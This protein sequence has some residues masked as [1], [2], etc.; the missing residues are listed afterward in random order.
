MKVEKVL[1]LGN[2]YVAN[3]LLNSIDKAIVSTDK[4]SKFSDVNKIKQK[5]SFI[6]ETPIIKITALGTDFIVEVYDDGSIFTAVD[7]GKVKVSIKLKNKNINLIKKLYKKAGE[8]I[9]NSLFYE[10]ILEKNEKLEISFDKY[11]ETENQADN[12]INEFI[13]QIKTDKN[14]NNARELIMKL[15]NE[16][17]EQIIK[18]NMDLLKKD[19]LEINNDNDGNKET[20]NIFTT[21]KLQ[22]N[23]GIILTEKNTYIS[24]DKNSI[25]ITS[26]SNNAVY[27]LEPK[28]G[29]L[30]WKFINEKLIDISSALTPFDDILVLATPINIMILNN[31]GKLMNLYPLDKGIYFWANPVKVDDKIYIPASQ[32]IIIYANNEFSKLANFNSLGQVYI[33]YHNSKLFYSDTNDKKVK[34]FDLKENKIIWESIQISNRFF[35]NPC[36]VDDNI[37]IGDINSNIYTF[38]FINNSNKDLNIGTGTISNFISIGK[39][40]YFVSDNGWFYSLN[41]INLANLNKLYRV[42]N[43]PDFNNYLVKK[44]LLFK[45]FIYFSSDTGK[46][47]SFDIQGK[48]P[49]LI[50]IKENIQHNPLIGTPVVIG[51]NI[52]TIDMKSNIY[53]IQKK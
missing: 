1:I 15:C 4:I 20:T 17:S 7:E 34:I 36:I 48:K 28:N 23:P 43:N 8:K 30:K 2:G 18:L 45:N 5:T 29:K 26:K 6:V 21:S 31:N 33:T 40:I 47:F 44:C 38:N 49:D 32:N 52:Y 25:Y 46:L 35:S 9:D 13:N 27:S 14:H 24:S 41:S 51:R 37:I 53:V 11:S 22:F 10:I 12:I 3:K 50:N 16:K 19:K 42:D 39:D